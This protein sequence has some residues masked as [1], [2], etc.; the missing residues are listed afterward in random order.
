VG[1]SIIQGIAKGI[2]GALDIIKN[3]AKNAADAALEAAKGF[4]GIHSPA[5]V[6]ADEIGEPTGEGMGM[7][8]IRAIP[9][10]ARAARRTTQAMMDAAASTMWSQRMPA[11]AEAGALGGG[12]ASTSV[13]IYGLTLEGVQDR[14]GLLAELKDLA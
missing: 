1:R 8:L 14:E 6:P 2:T 7:G 5:R 9:S 11:P 3:A 4:L 12:N 13:N 10:V